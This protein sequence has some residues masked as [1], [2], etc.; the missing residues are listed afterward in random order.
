MYIYKVYIY[1][2]NVFW[3]DRIVYIWYIILVNVHGWS[4]VKQSIILQYWQVTRCQCGQI[5]KF[6][7][8]P[9]REME[10]DSRQLHTTFREFGQGIGIWSNFGQILGFLI[11]K[12][13]LGPKMS[14]TLA[15]VEF[16]NTNLTRRIKW[17]SPELGILLQNS[18]L[19]Y[20]GSEFQLTPT[21][22]TTAC[23]QISHLARPLAHSAQGWN[24]PFGNPSLRW[25]D[26][27]LTRI[28]LTV[29]DLDRR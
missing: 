20:F 1:V 14:L 2:R 7:M 10:P 26:G 28:L 5:T 25:H 27:E 11:R 8:D 12:S 3:I 6:K 16:F 29:P 18:K 24:I 4:E 9:G 17:N 21:T 15:R 23:R 13:I 22:T 19:T